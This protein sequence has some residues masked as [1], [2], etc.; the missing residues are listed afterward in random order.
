MATPISNSLHLPPSLGPSNTSVVQPKTPATHG[1]GLEAAGDT[2]GLN[3]APDDQAIAYLREPADYFDDDGSDNNN[4]C[5]SC[6]GSPG[7]A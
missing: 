3:T 5:Q 1:T 2:S 4:D 7:M 6:L